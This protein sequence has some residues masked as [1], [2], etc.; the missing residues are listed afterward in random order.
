VANESLRDLESPGLKKKIAETTKE[1]VIKMSGE[2][3]DGEKKKAQKNLE[4]CRN[5]VEE[6][7]N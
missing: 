4:W 6:T 2:G 1:N 3:K 5:R 7:G